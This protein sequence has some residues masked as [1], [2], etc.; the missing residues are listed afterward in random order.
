MSKIYLNVAFDDKD[1]AKAS[2]AKW[3]ANTRKWYWWQDGTAP[4]PAELE[5]FAPAGG[6]K[7]EASIDAESAAIMASVQAGIPAAIIAAR[8]AMDA[9][10][11]KTT[12]AMIIAAMDHMGTIT[13]ATI[14]SN[15]LDLLAALASTERGNLDRFL[16]GK[17]SDPCRALLAVF[18]GNTT[19]ASARLSALQ[20]ASADILVRE[21][22]RRIG[23]QFAIAKNAAEKEARKVSAMAKAEET[24]AQINP[25]TLDLSTESFTVADAT[26]TLAIGNMSWMYIDTING[27]RD[28]VSSAGEFCTWLN[29]MPSVRELN[30]KIT[31][32]WL[33]GII[34]RSIPSSKF[35]RQ[36]A[37]E[38]I[39]KRAERTA[40]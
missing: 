15:A 39:A 7:S 8:A 22:M 30:D 6:G 32:K 2:G 1:E 35:E 29:Q 23:Q 19:T 20:G 14:A 5:Q 36:C 16:A 13:D 40:K 28:V 37:R 27:H 38:A 26:I 34:D 31:A 21:S 11:P 3:D 24:V 9:Q 12:D 17:A 25:D 4:L 10:R 18:G 33:A